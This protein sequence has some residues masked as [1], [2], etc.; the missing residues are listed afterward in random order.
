MSPSDDGEPI[1]TTSP[2]LPGNRRNRA[3]RDI[4]DAS[5]DLQID[6]SSG[7]HVEVHVYPPPGQGGAAPGEDRSR[8][9]EPEVALPSEQAGRVLEPG[10]GNEA[11]YPR[12]RP[13]V[14]AAVAI[15]T[16][17]VLLIGILVTH[18][19]LTPSRERETSPRARTPPTIIQLASSSTFFSDPNVQRKL[20]RLGIVV[21]QASLGSRQVCT[22]PNVIKSFDIE[23]SGSEEAAACVVSLVQKSGKTP[24]ED[25]PF[26]SLMV[27]ITYKPIVALLERLHVASVVNGITV[28]DVAKYLK[29]FA[30]GERWTGIPGNT[31]YLSDNR[32]LLWTTNP[33]E[34]NSGGML[35]DLAYA[36]QVGDDPPTSISPG[37]PHVP[38]IRS[39][40]TE[41]GS[42]E[43]HTPVLLNQFLTGGMGAYPMAM[44]Y[45]SDYLSVT[46]A[47]R[48]RDP[49]LTVMYPTPDVLPEDTLVA[50]TPAGKKLINIL[51]SPAMFAAE[52]AH[53]YR[54]ETDKTGFVRYMAGKGIDVPDLD[55]LE[56]TLQFSNLPTEHVLEELIN[57]VATSQPG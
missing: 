9:D 40:F 32:I 38:V 51:Q 41:S 48:P 26:G 19:I 18:G 50:W 25:S 31:T 53:G 34:S 17:I 20:R 56:R 52:E 23:D 47:G 1:T 22:E 30:S 33:K 12:R 15:G 24:D 54:T 55:E 11:P 35:A 44:V 49:N 5:R 2:G 13:W 21:Q 29:V 43:T 16:V 42:L 28:F 36:A 14:M 3:S 57:A 6:R 37:D 39:L 4:F 45:E 10:T 8:K 27:I 46:L 7:Q